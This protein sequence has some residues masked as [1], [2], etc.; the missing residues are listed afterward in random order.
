MHDLH[1]QVL[2]VNVKWHKILYTFKFYFMCSDIYGVF[3][4]F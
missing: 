3:F 4:T 2:V 1:V